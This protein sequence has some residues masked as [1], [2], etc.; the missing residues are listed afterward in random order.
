VAA[1]AGFRCVLSDICGFH[2]LNYQEALRK[3]EK[4]EKTKAKGKSKK[5]R[6]IDI[7]PDFWLLTSH[8][9]AIYV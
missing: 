2:L 6:K 5:V 9:N 3:R 7:T 8:N 4:G 1:L